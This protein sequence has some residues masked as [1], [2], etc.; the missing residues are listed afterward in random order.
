MYL[1][2]AVFVIVISVMHFVPS[3][4]Q[5]DYD[6]VSA[7]K[8][9]HDIGQNNSSN[10]PENPA[11]PGSAYASSTSGN[12]REHNATIFID[13]YDYGNVPMGVCMK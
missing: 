2:A 9:A 5:P 4:K 11:F 1:L 6:F 13:Y 10:F 8:V 3:I 12:C 7:L